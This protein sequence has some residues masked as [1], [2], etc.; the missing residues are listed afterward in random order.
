MLIISRPTK[1]LKNPRMQII[2]DVRT[3]GENF[4][5]VLWPTLLGKKLPKWLP[6]GTR[7]TKHGILRKTIYYAL[8]CLLSTEQSI[9]W[10]RIFWCIT[11]KMEK[12]GL[13]HRCI[14]HT[15]IVIVILACLFMA[16]VAFNTCI[17]TSEAKKKK[18]KSSD[19]IIA[20]IDWS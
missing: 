2:R 5:A 20:D 8:F 17:H 14:N 10:R 15:T 13:L 1:S 19:I 11:L 4:R 16:I 6:T 12:R 3:V 7:Y 18:R 9:K